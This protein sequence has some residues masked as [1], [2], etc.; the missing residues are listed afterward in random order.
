MLS[1]YFTD[2]FKFWCTSALKV[3]SFQGFVLYLEYKCCI[4]MF[5]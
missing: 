5:P 1:I 4:A 2:N 3:N